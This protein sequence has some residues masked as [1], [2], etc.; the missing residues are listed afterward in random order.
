MH[1]PVFWKNRQVVSIKLRRKTETVVL[2]GPDGIVVDEVSELTYQCNAKLK[3]LPHGRHRRSYKAYNGGAIDP[4]SPQSDDDTYGTM[5]PLTPF[6]FN[7]TPGGITP[8]GPRTH[9][10]SWRGM[11]VYIHETMEKPPLK[12]EEIVAGEIIG[13]RCWRVE[14]G[15]LR[16]VYQRDFWHPGKPLIAREIE[17]WNQRGIHA[18]KDAGGEGYHEYLRA[19][20]NKHDDPFT[21]VL[22]F[23]YVDKCENLRPAMVTGTVYLWGDVVEHQRGWRGEFARVRSIDWLYPDEHMM[24]FE[25][26]CLA[27]LRSRYNV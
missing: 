5:P 9:I 15:L 20:L 25:E 23:G 13:Y 4:T 27:S 17:D 21:Q 1:N 7:L 26:Q 11:Q 12:R 24:G 6:A 19:Y 8:I 2:F 3:G 18:W 16:S 22:M 14:G 10:G